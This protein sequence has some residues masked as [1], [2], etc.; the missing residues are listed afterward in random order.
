MLFY[1]LLYALN[2]DTVRAASLPQRSESSGGL[3]AGPTSPLNLFSPANILAPSKDN[4][5]SG[6][7]LKI[8]CDAT[9]YGKNLKVSSCRNIFH[10]LSKDET[11]FRFAQRDSGVPCDVPLPLR[12]MST[13]GLCF[14]Q[15]V[16]KK[17]AVIG[18]ATST[19]I[20]Q[21]AFTLLQTCVVERGMG[22]MA[23]DIGGDNNLGVAIANYKPNIK[24]DSTSA[25]GPLWKSCV[26]VFANMKA[27]KQ[28][29]IFGYS[30]DPGVD[31]GLPLVL[32][33]ADGKCQA[34]IDIDGPATIA[35]W[36]EMWEAVTAIANMCTRQ[37]RKGGKAKGLGLGKNIRLELSDKKDDG[38]G[39]KVGNSSTVSL[40][41]AGNTAMLDFAAA[42][43]Q[44]GSTG[45]ESQAVPFELLTGVVRDN[46][47]ALLTLPGGDHPWT[48]TSATA[49]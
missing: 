23:Y 18:R 48:N 7:V 12:T 6:N 32:E 31:E 37:K 33:A 16:L 34:S 42:S 21:A 5:T 14:V 2:S 40:A 19:E 25:A 8:A 10:F 47:S 38:P 26:A 13:D 1:F 3:A 39:D 29:R 17:D 45:F 24:C 30:G 28:A 41:D 36:Y 35:S 4:S 44:A 15:P 11:Q 22:G 20:G 9:L 43:S 49:R 27:T 46:E